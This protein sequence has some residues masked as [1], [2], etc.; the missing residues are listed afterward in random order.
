MMHKRTAIGC[1]NFGKFMDDFKTKAMHQ[2][3]HIMSHKPSDPPFE[4]FAKK[5]LFS[6]DRRVIQFL[7]LLTGQD[8]ATRSN[9]YLTTHTFLTQQG[10]IKVVIYDPLADLLHRG[11]QNDY[12][13]L[14]F[15]KNQAS[16]TN[17]KAQLKLQR[18]LK[19]VLTY[20]VHVDK[21]TIKV[22]ESALMAL[23]DQLDSHSFQVEHSSPSKVS[24]NIMDHQP[25]GKRVMR[26]VVSES[27]SKVFHSDP[28]ALI[29]GD[30]HHVLNCID[31]PLDISA[32][33]DT[34]WG[35]EFEGIATDSTKFH[36][37]VNTIGGRLS[38]PLNWEVQG[39]RDL[40][41]ACM[42]TRKNVEERNARVQELIRDA[43]DNWESVVRTHN[44][45]SLVNDLLIFHN[46]SEIHI[47][48]DQSLEDTHIERVKVNIAK[49]R[50]ILDELS[51]DLRK[52]PVFV[53]RRYVKEQIA[54]GLL[55]QAGPFEQHLA[56]GVSD[57]GALHAIREFIRPVPARYYDD[58]YGWFERLFNA[59]QTFET[60][61]DDGK[62]WIDDEINIQL[63][64][65]ID[66]ESL[67]MDALLNLQSIDQIDAQ[68]VV[69]ADQKANLS[70]QQSHRLQHIVWG[71]K[72][73]AQQLVQDEQKIT[74]IR[75]YVDR[76]RVGGYLIDIQSHFLGNESVIGVIEQ[77][78]TGF[79]DSSNGLFFEVIHREC[80]DHEDQTM[81]ESLGNIC[82]LFGL[83]N[84]KQLMK[85]IEDE[86]EK[87]SRSDTTV[88]SGPNHS[89]PRYQ[90]MIGEWRIDSKPSIIAMF[91]H[92]LLDNGKG[93]DCAS[94]LGTQAFESDLGD[95]FWGTGAI[96][97]IHRRLSKWIDEA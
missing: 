40:L 81:K 6:P 16:M 46:P 94:T 90:E 61:Q 27:D 14:D 8:G 63:L 35:I 62:R 58:V 26:T 79:M 44:T 50:S 69:F 83:R 37:M 36:T 76:A 29:K 23:K 25:C 1:L 2:N 68:S 97:H 95:D 55:F 47:S 73:N 54:M 9:G 41:I 82:G 85:L 49:G 13:N 91:Q 42:D 51:Q 4:S 57:M 87:V 74:V 11:G 71:L 7:K 78:F 34:V 22:K 52:D 89:I 24:F 12:E 3:L 53:L 21:S 59:I 84:F 64:Q 93:D 43:V 48:D 65:C 38:F 80:R 86:V 33:G 96:Q 10:E 92:I 15:S 28:T 60:M 18:F 45:H 20:G 31:V 77:V 88:S 56:L 17:R 66:F 39:V 67:T 19:A 30:D 72:L 70:D 32:L 5:R 75:D